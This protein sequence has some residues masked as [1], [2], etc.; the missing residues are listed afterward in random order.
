MEA[1]RPAKAVASSFAQVDRLVALAVAD[2]L[3][4]SGVAVTKVNFFS[5]AAICSPSCF[6]SKQMDSHAVITEKLQA[7]EREN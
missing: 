1:P 4:C 3:L 6:S 5:R 2:K 7:D